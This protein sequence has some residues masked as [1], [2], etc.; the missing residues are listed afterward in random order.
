MHSSITL[1]EEIEETDTNNNITKADTELDEGNTEKTLDNDGQ[2]GVESAGSQSS[3]NTDDPKKKR[4]Q[5]RQ[6]THF[7]A[8]Q[9][10]ELEAFFARNRY[11]DISMREEI[12]MWTSLTEARV[13][14]WFKNRRAKWRKKERNNLTTATINTEKNVFPGGPGF[15]CEGTTPADDPFFYQN[16]AWNKSSPSS[17][18]PLSQTT[19]GYN[20]AFSPLAQPRASSQITPQNYNPTSM[21]FNPSI[22]TE[23]AFLGHPSQQANLPTYQQSY[24]YQN[25]YQQ[26]GSFVGNTQ[27][28]LSSTSMINTA[29]KLDTG[30]SRYNPIPTCLYD[31]AT[32]PSLG[33]I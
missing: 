24:A 20:N 5:R 29:N 13:R 8:Y 11:P 15:R 17:F 30:S 16:Y 32:R 10:Q 27:Q 23:N 33:S 18:G 26:M 25:H 7:T 3:D 28:G 9:L 14:V 2:C 12:A 4:K 19:T 31:V 21:C 6:R 1:K 22:T